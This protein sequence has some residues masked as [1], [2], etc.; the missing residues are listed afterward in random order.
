MNTD[1]KILAA[2]RTEFAQHGLAGARVDRIASRAGVNKAMIYYH[3]RS[4]ENLY[5]TVISNE[6]AKIGTILEERITEES[7]PES[8]LY[9]LSELYNSMFEDR[10]DFIR[11][12]L[13]E[14]A[15]GGEV[16]KEIMSKIMSERG[17][18]KKTKRILD[19]GKKKGLFRDVD[20]KQAIISFVGMNVFYLTMAPLINSVWEI[21]D[22]KKFRQRRCKEV[23]DLFLHG[24]K[25]R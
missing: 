16:V 24:L 9:K 3:F 17:I 7:T 18:V 15:S 8:L 25:A 2:A 20:S 23:V 22:E 12:L 14:I 10:D 19:K 21:K 4:K 5:R 1:E 13:R 11:I 6:L